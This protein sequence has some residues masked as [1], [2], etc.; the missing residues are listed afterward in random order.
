MNSRE[1]AT[2]LAALTE[3]SGE[4]FSYTKNAAGFDAAWSFNRTNRLLGGF[5]WDSI[6]R[7]A[8]DTEAPKSDDYRYWV[9]YRNS[10]WENLSGRLKYEFLQRRSD[11]VNTAAATSVTHYYTAYDV[12]N[13]D[14]NVVKLNVD[15]TPGPLWFVGLGATWRDVDYKDNLYGRTK[16]KNQQY[17]VTVSWGDVEKLRITGIGNWGK[18]ENNQVYRNVGSTISSPPTFTGAKPDAPATAST[19]T[20]AATTART[21]GCSPRSPTGRRPTSWSSRRRT[22]TR[23]RPAE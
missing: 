9:E 23:S 18:V 1:R 15:W 17:D 5:D 4:L 13:F 8:V 3:E 6:K 7:Q 10:G 2:Q 21:A 12:N 22:A 16:D 14:A 19:T 20:G 11:L